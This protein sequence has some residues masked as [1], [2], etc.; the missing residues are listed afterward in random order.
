MR[1]TRLSILIRCMFRTYSVFMFPT[2][3]DKISYYLMQ[4]EWLA[5]VETNAYYLNVRYRC[6]YARMENL[7][8]T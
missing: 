5:T 6:H 8:F 2:F 1:K 7:R 4:H 3:L